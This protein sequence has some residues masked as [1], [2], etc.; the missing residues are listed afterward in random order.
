MVSTDEKIP[1]FSLVACAVIA[2][3]N[4]RGAPLSRSGN[5]INT[6]M[7]I[8]QVPRRYIAVRDPSEAVVSK[9]NIPH[10]C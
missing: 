2:T 10:S 5:P 6:R 8:G 9:W 3:V 4:P 1:G 7:R